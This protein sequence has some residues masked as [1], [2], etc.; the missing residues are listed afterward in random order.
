[1]LKGFIVLLLVFMML[2][3]PTTITLA[4]TLIEDFDDGDAEGWERSPQNEKSKV[5]WGVKDGAMMF[6]PKGLAWN[7]AISQMNFVGTSKVSN[8]R[9]WTDYDVEVEIKLTEIQNYPGGVR[10]RVDL[11]TGGHYV[12]WLYP[13]SGEIKLYKNPGWDINTGIATVGSGNFAPKVDEYH[14]VK[15]S[16]KGDSIKVYYDGKVIIDATDKE[17]KKGTI[18]VGSQ[19]RVVYFDNIIVTGPQIPNYNMSPVEPMGKLTTVWG[20]IKVN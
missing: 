4:G 2:S 7:L 15:L 13:A 9:D 16:M 12:V 8:V 18:A 14:K 5:F 6:D 19:D 17:H 20:R 1:M 11:D 10:G 3:T